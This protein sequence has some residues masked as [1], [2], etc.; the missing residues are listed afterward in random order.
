MEADLY[1][2]RTDVK[3]PI[4]NQPQECYAI[5]SLNRMPAGS[6]EDFWDGK[7][8]GKDQSPQ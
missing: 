7:S 8:D 6:T 5:I 2:G 4:G 3:T 1:S